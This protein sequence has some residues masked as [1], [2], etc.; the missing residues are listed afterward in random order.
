MVKTRIEKWPCRYCNNSSSVG[1][2]MYCPYNSVNSHMINEA[3]TKML[4]LMGEE[5]EEQV[6]EDDLCFIEGWWLYLFSG[7]TAAKPSST[8]DLGALELVYKHYC[9]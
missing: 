1:H 7:S 2:S 6:D 5:G 3:Y 9:N 8:C 4:A